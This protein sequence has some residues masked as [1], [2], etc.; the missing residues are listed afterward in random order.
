MQL[1]I[2]IKFVFIE[3]RLKNDRSTFNFY[4]SDS[5]FTLI[6]HLCKYIEINRK[7][8]QKLW[9]VI[10]ISKR[11]WQHNFVVHDPEISLVL[12]NLTP[13]H[14]LRFTVLK[15]N[16]EFLKKRNR[17][18]VDIWWKTKL[19]LSLIHKLS[20]WVTSFGHSSILVF[21]CYVAWK[22]HTSPAH[23]PFY[24]KEYLIIYSLKY[25]CDRCMR[26]CYYYSLLFCF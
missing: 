12:Q 21:L 26:N 20:I 15:V 23:I 22:L 18:F 11:P 4:V 9:S 25:I 5:P 13:Y 8:L 2:G 17:R 1:Y 14:L 19:S 16:N 7:W 6:Y 24:V 10:N 3:V